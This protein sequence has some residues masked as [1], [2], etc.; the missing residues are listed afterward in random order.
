MSVMSRTTTPATPRSET[1]ASCS[2]AAG[3]AEQGAET[4]WTE[5][6]AGFGVGKEATGDPEPAV[7][8]APGEPAAD[9][10]TVGEW[11]LTEVLLPEAAS[12][13]PARTP[14]AILVIMRSRI[15]ARY[16]QFRLD[17]RQP[18]G[19]RRHSGVQRGRVAGAPAAANSS[20]PLRP[21]GGVQRL[22]NGLHVRIGTPRRGHGDRPGAAGRAPSGDPGRPRPPARAPSR[23][24]RPHGPERPPRSGAAVGTHPPAR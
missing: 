1:S 7:G 6:V 11:T 10:D 4:A 18:E 19:R 20:R 12:I 16:L 9:D 14:N 24:L 15:L 3:G 13:N 22:F 8:D 2:P 23:H 17:D 5:E 21:G